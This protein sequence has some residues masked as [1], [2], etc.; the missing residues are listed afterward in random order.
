MYLLF[1]KTTIYY[2]EIN[3]GPDQT[4]G[5]VLRRFWRRKQNQ[6]LEFPGDFSKAKSV[7]DRIEIASLN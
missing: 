2:N 5:G 3:Y 7:N 1:I 4:E 6:F